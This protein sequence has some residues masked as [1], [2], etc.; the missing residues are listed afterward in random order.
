MIFGLLSKKLEEGYNKGE[1][2]FIL[3]GIPQTRMQAVSLNLIQLVVLF[4]ALARRHC[5]IY[6]VIWPEYLLALCCTLLH[7]PVSLRVVDSH[8]Q[9]LYAKSFADILLVSACRKSLIKWRILI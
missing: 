9:K 4:S 1:S 5:N 7:C 3:D 6:F 2:G 8:E